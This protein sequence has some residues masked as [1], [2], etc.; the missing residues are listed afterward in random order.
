MPEVQNFD[1]LAL[2]LDSIIDQDRCVDQLAHV[3]AAGNWASDVWIASQQLQVIENCSSKMLG[4]GRE[5][6]PGVLD[7]LL[8]FLYRRL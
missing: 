5:V 2:F 6:G 7:D 4:G 8:E 3:G 1:N